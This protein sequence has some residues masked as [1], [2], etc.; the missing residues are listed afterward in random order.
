MAGKTRSYGSIPPLSSHFNKYAIALL[1]KRHD[2]EAKGKCEQICS[3][4]DSN[5]KFKH[6]R[7]IKREVHETFPDCYID[8][9]EKVNVPQMYGM[10][11]LRKKEM[12]L[13]DG[14]AN[15]VEE[16]RL[17]HVTAKSRAKNS[18]KNSGLDWRRTERSRYGCGV[19][20]SD[21]IT[22]ADY[23]A[24][25]S[26]S[27]GDRV[28]MI[29]SV[30]VD[31]TYKVNH[32]RNKGYNLIVPPGTADTTVSSDGCVYVKYNDFDFYPLYFVHYQS[33]DYEEY[34]DDED[35]DNNY[36]YYYY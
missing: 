28:I 6:I 1:Q 18:L 27:E 9:I 7:Q 3:T 10:Y 13:N 14:K 26:T 34:Y 30:L 23:H 4:L 35:Y 36:N 29:C 8:W 31:E 2:F 11:L 5:L 24:N 15:D 20:F 12:Q 22:Y 19:S 21:N 32:K 17:Y 16:M 33:N 25:K